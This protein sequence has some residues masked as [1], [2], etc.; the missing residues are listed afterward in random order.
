M[1]EEN[2]TTTDVVEAS[3]KSPSNSGSVP[4]FFFEEKDKDGDKNGFDKAGEMVDAALSAG[5]MHTIKT[6]DSVREQILKTSNSV[7]DSRLN[8]AQNKANKEDKKTFFE[9]NEAACGYFGYD[10]KTTNKSH[11]RLMSAWAWFF[12]TL[13]ILTI[14]FFI[15]APITFFCHKLRVVIKQTWLVIVLALLIYV[16]IIGIPILASW[17]GGII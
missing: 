13:Y 8:A 7:I 14:G 16:G 1:S 12:N 5:V 9:A 3:D 10:E 2:V 17:L 6:S 11:V 15:V 4:N